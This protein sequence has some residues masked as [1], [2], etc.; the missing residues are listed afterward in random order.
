M[1]V[2]E[3]PTDNSKFLDKKREELRI[4]FKDAKFPPEVIE[5]VIENELKPLVQPGNKPYIS[6]SWPGEV[7]SE[8]E[9]MTGQPFTKI[10]DSLLLKPL[11]SEEIKTML[12]DSP[13][14][15]EKARQIQIESSTQQGNDIAVPFEGINLKN[16]NLINE[17]RSTASGNDEELQKISYQNMQDLMKNADNVSFQLRRT[18]FKRVVEDEETSNDS[19]DKDLDII[20]KV[21]SQYTDKT[22]E[23]RL[24]E[25]KNM[26]SDLADKHEGIVSESDEIKS[27]NKQINIL[28]EAST[29]VL[30]SIDNNKMCKEIVES[31]AINEKLN[32]TSRNKPWKLHDTSE[33]KTSDIDVTE[34]EAKETPSGN[35]IENKLKST[36]N[37][38]QNI[39]AILDGRRNMS[40]ENGQKFDERMEETLQHALEDIFQVGSNDND[41]N[42]EMEYNEMRMLAK[43]IVDGAENLGTLI[44]EDITNKLNSMNE[45]LHDVNTALETSKKS[46]IEYQKL[47]EGRF[48]PNTGTIE[49]V[50]EEKS[51][52][53]NSTEFVSRVT[54]SQIDDIH[55]AIGKLNIEIK[56][57]EER[58][59]Q[60]KERYEV[61]NKE[62]KQFITEVD[63]ILEKSREILHPVEVANE[64]LELVKEEENKT[65]SD[66]K[67]E[68]PEISGDT[69]T[70]NV[71]KEAWDIDYSYK[72]EIINTKLEEFKKQELDRNKRINTLLYDIKD[73]MKDNREVLQLA[74]NLLRREE[75]RKKVLEGKGRCTITE[76][77]DEPIT[78]DKAKG[79]HI[80]TS[81]VLQECK[82]LDEKIPIISNIPPTEGNQGNSYK[83]NYFQPCYLG[84]E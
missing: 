9:V 45:L 37:V 4:F 82:R 72:E 83:H 39:D 77:T 62:C 38:L 28:G 33:D 2:P 70:E 21:V 40:T 7:K 74:N 32:I 73:K 35:N 31:Y 43:N 19:D 30:S 15:A 51:Q 12:K 26:L 58:V 44:R 52:D 59:N 76:I 67:K 24:I 18:N 78:D 11:S 53:N 36:N 80:R 23:T 46:N 65:E 69:I 34:D 16:I 63:E 56:H 5:K 1:D 57:H 14:I 68:V 84:L 66:F 47:K 3:V 17:E 6:A 71:R 79:D 22:Y 20:E 13:E 60:S 42:R 55:T 61:R 48:Q 10:D 54:D 75:D 49:E 8:Y 29:V 64:K 41:E 50:E 81:S 27:S 25:T